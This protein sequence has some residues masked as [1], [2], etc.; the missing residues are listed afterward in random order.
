MSKVKNSKELQENKERD[1]HFAF[2][3]ELHRVHSMYRKAIDLSKDISIKRYSQK[4]Y[5]AFVDQIVMECIAL[6]E[7]ERDEKWVHTEIM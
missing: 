5:R 6:S 3:E 2:F 1:L 7:I 4:E